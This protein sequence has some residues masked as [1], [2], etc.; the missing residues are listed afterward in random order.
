M[1]KINEI[2]YSIQG[3][4]TYAGFP[5]VFI[6]LTGCSLRCNWCDTRYAYDDGKNMS[7]DDVLSAV[8]KYP[9]Q[10]V[11]ITGGEPLLQKET[12]ALADALLENGYEVFMETSGACD[13][14]MISEKV[15]RIVDVKCPDSGMSDKMD[16]KNLHRLRKND[17]VKFVI[18]SRKDFEF[19]VEKVNKNK[20]L[21]NF[22]LLI[23]PVWDRVD[24][25]ELSSWI[26]EA[27]LLF[28]LQLQLHKIIWPDVERGV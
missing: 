21:Q 8:K 9:V 20:Q 14:N 15:H 5:F 3:E 25:K 18:A 22:P 19:A 17:E 1:L 4:S 10:Y 12:P 2:F 23:S 13:I 26:L 16:W 28:R 27:G 7:I 11:E 6:R 24:V